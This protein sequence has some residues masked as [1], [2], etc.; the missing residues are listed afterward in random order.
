MQRSGAAGSLRQSAVKLELQDIREEIAG[1]RDVCRH[2]ILRARIEEFLTPRSNRCD[3]LILQAEIPPCFVVVVGRHFSRKYF[4][5]PLVNEETE[6][7]K[8]Y[9]L[10]RARH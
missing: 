5:A 4:P 8:R 9:F 7:N 1:V 2:V 6:R 10:E 3:A